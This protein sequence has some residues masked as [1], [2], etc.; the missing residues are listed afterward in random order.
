TYLCRNLAC[1]VGSCGADHLHDFPHRADLH[2]HAR[3]GSSDVPL[4]ACG[5]AFTLS[6]KRQFDHGSRGRC[7]MT[8]RSERPCAVS[9]D[10]EVMR[11]ASQSGS[12]GI[13]YKPKCASSANCRFGGSHCLSPRSEWRCV[14]STTV[15]GCLSNSAR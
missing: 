11:F 9:P 1:V 6:P 10:I 2:R 14:Q 12:Q 8:A 13:S 4:T 3:P 15:R 5:L 7:S